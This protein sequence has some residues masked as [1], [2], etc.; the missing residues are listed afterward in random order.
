MEYFQ[1]IQ[2]KI[3]SYEH[4]VYVHKPDEY[5]LHVTTI[6]SVQTCARARV[7]VA[8][9]KGVQVNGNTCVCVFLGF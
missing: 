7:C 8:I 5:L 6:C 9:F 1:Y 3:V 2:C 4:Y